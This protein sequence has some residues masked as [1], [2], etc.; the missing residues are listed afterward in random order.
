MKK[1]FFRKPE[2]EYLGF[3]VTRNGIQTINKKVENI[4]N[5]ISPKIQ[6]QVHELIGLVNYYMYM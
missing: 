1:S 3:W 2:M 5:N 4:V 6:K